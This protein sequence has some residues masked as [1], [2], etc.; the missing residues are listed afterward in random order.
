MNRLHRS[1]G[2]SA[3]ERYGSSFFILLSTAVLARLLTREEFGIYT[4]T[5]A[6]AALATVSSREFGG[7]NY[8]IQK[9][10]LSEQNI[11]T[12]FTISAC[13]SAVLAALLF[14]IRDVAASFYSQEGMRIAIT[15]AA[16]NFLLL[17]FSSTMSALLRREMAFDIIARCNLTANFIAALASISLAALGYS[18]MSPILGALTGHGTL[19]M[20]LIVSRPHLRIFRPCLHGWRDVVGFGAHSSGTAIINVFYQM[21]PQLII[22][23]VIDFAAVGLYGRA[24]TVTQIFDRLVLEVVNPVIMPAISART[25]A[26]A[27][28]KR[29]YLRS[30]E[31]ISAVQWPSL[32]FTALMAD[33][34]V[35]ILL[36]PAWGD[37]V[38][39]IRMLSLASLSMFSASL[40]YPVL[41]A[42]GRVR[43]VLV[44]SLISVPPSL[45]VILGASFFGVR[46]VAASALLTLPFQV[47]VALY[48]IRR[49][50][51]IGAADLAR[52]MVKSG[53]VAA[54]SAAGVMSAVAINDF[55]FEVS[56]LGFVGAGAA[57][58][59]GWWLGLI[60]TRHP[61]LVQMRLAA[62]D[63][64]AAMPQFR[65][66][67]RKKSFVRN[68]KPPLGEF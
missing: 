40:T 47:L 48:F 18:F 49:H 17:P 2:F 58:L 59:S 37:T 9:T 28:L 13:M 6:L 51:S 61:L 22:A 7:A 30:I 4:A 14:V 62:K 44:A 36:G 32:I 24:V 31:L 42:I 15:F 33:P 5:Y 43:D 64:I 57:G 1:I 39:L 12:A 11:R 50:L 34:I 65:F 60:M 20:L 68:G 38:P 19:V 10:S 46:A 63:I 55:S 3:V 35:W 27:D 25:R 54:C 56:T 16:L 45:L 23:R 53:M 41:V 67:R 66:L 8:L 26:G 52:A 29:I 21:S